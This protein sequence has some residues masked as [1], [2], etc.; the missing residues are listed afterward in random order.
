[1]LYTLKS[2][3]A[4]L[5]VDSLGAE[6]KSLISRDGVEY[7][8]QADPAVWG[9]TS[10]ILFPYIGR[11]WNGG[12]RYRGRFYSL[13]QHGFASKAEFSLAAREEGRLVLSLVS[14]EKTKEMY[15][16]DFAFFVEYVLR[17]N[18]L[19]VTYRVENRG[20]ER[21]YFGLGGHPGFRVPLLEG[22][23]FEDYCIRF[24]TPALPSRVGFTPQVFLSD[25]DEAYPL[26][27]E[28]LLPLRHTLFDEDA[29]IL[30][31][32]ARALTLSSARSGRGVRVEYPEMPYLGIWHWPKTEAQ[33]VCIEPW[34]GLP[35]R[36]GVEEEISAKSDLLSLGARE[37]LERG[38][39]V[40]LL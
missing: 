38:F 23:A 22:E 30:K 25:R 12:Y 14:D 37:S 18:R 9:E 29:I 24:H 21:M 1:M 27:E 6:M 40:T 34:C 10:P 16:F 32:A 28:A 17:E 26:A 8:W 33:Y 2:S 20:E 13:P 15:P 19:L 7:L 39:S 35:S 11:L 3:E 5:R 36:H 31:N 4:T